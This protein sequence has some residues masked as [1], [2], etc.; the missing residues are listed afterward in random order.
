[1]TIDIQP[2]RTIVPG[3]I[4][5]EGPFGIIHVTKRLAAPGQHHQ[6]T[7]G[8]CRLLPLTLAQLLAAAHIRR[9]P[10]LVCGTGCAPVRAQHAGWWK[11][12]VVT[13]QSTK[14]VTC[15]QVHYNNCKFKTMFIPT[16]TNICKTLCCS[17]HYNLI[18][19]GS[20]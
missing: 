19:L 11:V 2:Y 9:V 5:D 18:V 14:R 8:P 10:V 15:A 20:T 13:P 7:G 1:M 3:W 12:D 4:H 17:Q 6:K 16:E